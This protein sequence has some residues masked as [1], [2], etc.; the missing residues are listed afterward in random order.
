[1]YVAA[2]EHAK[3]STSFPTKKPQK[4]RPLGL[5]GSIENTLE[6]LPSFRIPQNISII[7]LWAV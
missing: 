1:M 2:S 4:L 6:A 7:F 3:H 5:N